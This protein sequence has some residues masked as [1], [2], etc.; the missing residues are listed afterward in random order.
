VTNTVCSEHMVLFC[1]V[2][3]TVCSERMVLFCAVS[4]VHS[5]QH[6]NV[7]AAKGS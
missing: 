7:Q 1:A 2:T 5:Q 6:P 3:N 4:F